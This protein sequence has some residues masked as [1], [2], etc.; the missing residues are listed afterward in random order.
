MSKAEKSKFSLG[1]ITNKYL[2]IEIIHYGIGRRDIV[3][4]FYKLSKRFRLMLAQ[5][6]IFITSLRDGSY[7]IKSDKELDYAYKQINSKVKIQVDSG[8]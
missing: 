1:K 3:M 5:N 4:T 2:I 7:A 6:L 8:F